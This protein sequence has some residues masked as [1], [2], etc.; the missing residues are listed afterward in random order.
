[1]LLRRL[2][3]VSLAA[4]AILA[5]VDAV[6]AKGLDLGI[7]WHRLAEQTARWHGP[8]GSGQ[9]PSGEP[10]YSVGLFF[11]DFGDRHRAR[12][13]LRYTTHQTLHEIDGIGRSFRVQCFL[14]DYQRQVLWHNP[15]R[16]VADLCVGLST[17]STHVPYPYSYSDDLSIDVH[18]PVTV[19]PGLGW[20]YQIARQFSVQAGVWYYWILEDPGEV[21]P[22]RSG[23]ALQLGLGYTTGAK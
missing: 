8:E 7:G 15:W 3:A 21:V 16:V 4:L 20:Q 1:M 5:G 19:A 23:P 18:A 10:L 13:G 6:H 17:F 14:F 9:L 12:I 2:F 11:N 22:F